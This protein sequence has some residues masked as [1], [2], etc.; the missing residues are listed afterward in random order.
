[1][2]I[3][4]IGTLTDFLGKLG[5]RWMDAKV[6]EAEGKVAVARAKATA[7]AHIDISKATAEAQWNLSHA[8]ASRFSWKDEFW[9]IVLALPVIG[10]FIPNLSD[11]VFE[12]FQ[13]LESLPDW[14]KAALGV[15]IGA[16]FGYRKIVDYMLRRKTNG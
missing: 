4:L 8:D 7:A 16:A 12:G 6:I 15:A 5:Q 3:P 9:T 13:R 1:M 2:N 10:V 14:Y 11:H